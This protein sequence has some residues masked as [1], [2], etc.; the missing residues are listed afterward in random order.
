MLKN[1]KKRTGDPDCPTPVKRAKWIQLDID[2]SVHVFEDEDSH[3]SSDNENDEH[4]LGD[5]TVEE[6]SDQTHATP[7][8]SATLVAAADTTAAAPLQSLDAGS[9][10]EVHG[11][12]RSL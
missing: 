1:T 7:D 12:S 6:S 3:Q 8:S 11:P 4:M 2:N 9:V 5:S 10:A